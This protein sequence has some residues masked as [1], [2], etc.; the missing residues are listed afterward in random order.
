VR[1]VARDVGPL[2]IVGALALA[3]SY[4]LAPR[5]GTTMIASI[6]E[7]AN[8]VDGADYLVDPSGHALDAL[9]AAL[10][11]A[12]RGEGS[13]RITIYGGSHT[14]SDLYTG[15]MREVLQ[16]RFG[17][18]G[19]GF[20]PIV[21]VIQEQ[22]RWGVRIDAAEG[23]E[24]LQVGFKHAEV[25]RYGMAGVSFL[26]DE[27]AAFAAVES[28]AWGNG[29]YASRI[30]VLFDRRPGG[31]S[32]D[33][34]LDG[35]VVEHVR[36]HAEVAES[37][38]REHRVSDGPHR[39]EVRTR[40][41]G[42]VIVYG[43][44]FDRDEPGVQVENLG[45]VGSKVRHQLFWEESSWRAFFTPR[46]PDLIALAYGTNEVEDTH[47]TLADQERQLRQVI[48]RLR[49]AAPNASCLL[50]GPTDRLRR[51]ADGGLEPEPMLVELSRMQ[52][53]VAIDVGC[54]FFDTLAW[55]GGPGAGIR[56]MQHDP[57]LMRDDLIHLTGLGYERWGDALID[58]LLHGYE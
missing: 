31:G 20:A 30:A 13:A 41:D 3:T 58:A 12:E 21:P 18:A 55:Q 6:T 28:E 52:R 5:G 24:V 40:G 32:F 29:R 39:L 42:P 50:I 11:R 38:M 10:A 17:D 49:S 44:L 51:R 37:G 25:T 27:P 35:R 47:L 7:L 54:A 46:Q 57:P 36:T 4:A 33:V 2:L 16:A 1:R 43:V 56:W 15:R 8:R 48:A 53:A 19:H 26:A 23:W 45:L 34:L 22:W 9:H 14:A